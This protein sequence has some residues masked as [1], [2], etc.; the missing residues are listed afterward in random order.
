[1]SCE[2]LLPQKSE[3]T[4]LIDAKVV[5]E[6]YTNAELQREANERRESVYAVKG[7]RGKESRDFDFMC[8]HVFMVADPRR[9]RLLGQYP[10]KATENGSDADRLTY[11]SILW[12]RNVMVQIVFLL[13]R[14]LMET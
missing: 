1:M 5:I 6:R 13:R 4:L 14:E 3:H 2:F 7:I 10:T 11:R 9:T 8:N 12:G